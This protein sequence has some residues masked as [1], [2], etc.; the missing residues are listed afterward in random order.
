MREAQEKVKKVEEVN[1][2]L[3]PS[4]DH[5]RKSGRRQSQNM[6]AK[7]IVIVSKIN[8]TSYASKNRT[9]PRLL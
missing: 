9:T 3:N 4:Q 1:E 6:A 8:T 5:G 2:R 7:P